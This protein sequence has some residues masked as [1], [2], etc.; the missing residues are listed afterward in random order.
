MRVLV[1]AWSYKQ[2]R[3]HFLLYWTINNVYQNLLLSGDCMSSTT[4]FKFLILATV[5]PYPSLLPQALMKSMGIM[6][7]NPDLQ[8]EN[9]NSVN[10]R[11]NKKL[12]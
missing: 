6:A 12:V 9:A 5:L 1:F 2:K 3:N 11:A 4:V 8:H 7:L 10:N